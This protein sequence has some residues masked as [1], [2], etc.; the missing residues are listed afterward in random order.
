ML[1]KIRQKAAAAVNEIHQPEFWTWN[2]WLRPLPAKAYTFDIKKLKL[3][4]KNYFPEGLQPVENYS[5]GKPL[6]PGTLRKN[7]SFNRFLVVR[8]TKSRGTPIQKSKTIRLFFSAAP[9]AVS[10][11]HIPEWIVKLSENYF[12]QWDSSVSHNIAQDERYR[13]DVPEIVRPAKWNRDSHAE[14]PEVREI[15]SGWP[16]AVPLIADTGS[17]SSFPAGTVSDCSRLLHASA[18]GDNIMSDEAENTEII[19]YAGSS[20]EMLPDVCTVSVIDDLH[21]EIS[22]SAD[23]IHSSIPVVSPDLIGACNTEVSDDLLELVSETLEISL[24]E[25]GEF[26][27][28]E[29]LDNSVE[30]KDILP[31]ANKLLKFDILTDI[32]IMSTFELYAGEIVSVNVYD[33]G[34]PAVAPVFESYLD[35]GKYKTKSIENISFNRLTAISV[36]VPDLI[37]TVHQAATSEYEFSMPAAAVGKTTLVDMPVTE[38]LEHTV[39]AVSRYTVKSAAGE[40]ELWTALSTEQRNEYESALSEGVNKLQSTAGTGNI[41]MLKPQIFALLHQLNQILNFPQSLSA[42]PKSEELLAQ[43]KKVYPSGDRIIIFSQYEKM[44]IK[45]IEE[46]L[47]ENNIPVLLYLSSYSAVQAQDVFRRF[48]SS[49]EN[50]ILIA[51]AKAV[52]KKAGL[53]DVKHAFYFDRWWNPLNNYQAQES[54]LDSSAENVYCFYSYGTIDE[55]IKK[56]LERKGIAD[57]TAAKK[58]TMA[59]INEMITTE[60]WLEQVF[61]L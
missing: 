24:L 36:D 56:M 17:F 7:D 50:A 3:P 31:A 49:R 45:K 1:K 53:R 59:Q 57:K 40:M 6:P 10:E 28:E 44:G 11:N 48:S 33:I 15:A 19:P 4:K 20:Y 30:L 21:P 55:R 42:T 16:V 51:D 58:Y 47:K 54:F 41:F 8:S 25:P 13:T 61:H 35:A 18:A 39:D 60:E 34:K 52:N 12:P 29:L 23:L 46:L 22:V 14:L 26:A 37:V 5:H 38:T 27:G 32:S 9:A 43:V 2:R